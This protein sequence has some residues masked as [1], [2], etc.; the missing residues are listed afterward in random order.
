VAAAT[1]PPVAVAAAVASE[2]PAEPHTVTRSA[3]WASLEGPMPGTSA[4]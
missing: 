1:A 3:S 2:Q 4:S